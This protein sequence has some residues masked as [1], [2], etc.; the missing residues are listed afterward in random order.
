MEAAVDRLLAALDALDLDPD[1]ELEP[2]LELDP[3]I[4]IECEDEGACCED[5]GAHDSDLEPSLGSTH[6]VDQRYSYQGPTTGSD[7]HEPSL[8]WPGSGPQFV[9]NQSDSDREADDADLE[10]S[11]GAPEPSFFSVLHEDSAGRRVITTYSGS[12]QCWAQGGDE[13]IEEDQAERGIA[14]GDAL[15]E[16]NKGEADSAPFTGP[17]PFAI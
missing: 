7:D 10:P 5:E 9:L 2:D 14:D 4:E 12:Q 3:D 16:L 8:G 6:C 11:L 15:W 17:D 13:D 1:L